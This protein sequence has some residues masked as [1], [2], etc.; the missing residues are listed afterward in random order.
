MADQQLEW[1]W[2]RMPRPEPAR[3]AAPRARPA[4]AKKSAAPVGAKSGDALQEGLRELEALIEEIGNGRIGPVQHNRLRITV[5][6]RASDNE[7][8]YLRITTRDYPAKASS[9]TFVDA[10]GAS[11]ETAWPGYDTA[12]H[13][14]PPTLICTP[15]TAEFYEYHRDRRYDPHDGTLVNLVC[16]I[17]TALNGRGYSGRFKKRSRVWRGRP[18]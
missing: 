14:R 15:P 18:R 5:P 8:Y 4:A 1:G 2:K 11:T 12:G 16:T 7:F 17:F 6:M 13:F 3:P 10:D 9:C